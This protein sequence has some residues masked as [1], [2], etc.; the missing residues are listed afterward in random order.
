MIGTALGGPFGTVAA[1]F[2]ANALGLDKADTRTVTDLL[3]GGKMSPEQI[4]QLK[5]AELEFNKFCIAHDID[6]ETLEVD[7]QKSARQML[8]STNSSTPSVLTYIITVGFFGIL[9][10]MMS[11]AYKPSEPLLVMLG[12]LGTAW[13]ATISFWFGSTSGS[14]KKSELLANSQPAK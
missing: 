9:M 14:A 5:L 10:Y 11:S 12:S 8:M 13:T 1:T 2:V 3:T 6:K 7:N 4:T